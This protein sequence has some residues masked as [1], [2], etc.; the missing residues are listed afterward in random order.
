MD[1]ITVGYYKDD[2]SIHATHR[3]LLEAG[4]YIL[5]GC[6]L[7]D[8]PPGEYELVCL[9]LRIL[10]GDASPCRAILRPLR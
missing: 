2:A 8:V 6:A 1:A 7:G 3:S 4:I 10:A 9:P 5:E